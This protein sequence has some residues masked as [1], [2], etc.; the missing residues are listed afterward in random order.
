MSKLL[1]LFLLLKLIILKL[2]VR[3]NLCL[4]IIFFLWKRNKEINPH[5]IYIWKIRYPPPHTHHF[6]IIIIFCLSINIFFLLNILL[7]FFVCITGAFWRLIS[8]M[9][10]KITLLNSF[11]VNIVRYQVSGLPRL[12]E[13]FEL[14][15]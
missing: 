12:I 14:A 3:R 2:F 4:I 10:K 9:K 7:F 6:F 5:W 15:L 1:L 11:Y 8:H 13:P